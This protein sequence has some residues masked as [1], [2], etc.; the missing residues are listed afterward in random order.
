MRNKPR[1]TDSQP[2]ETIGVKPKSQKCFDKAELAALD[3][4]FKASSGLP[5]RATKERLSN[6]L[7]LECDAVG[8]T[9]RSACFYVV[10][11]I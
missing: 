2:A 7:G 1:S 3:T 9:F 6:S 11:I 8:L 10:V 5:S 4:V